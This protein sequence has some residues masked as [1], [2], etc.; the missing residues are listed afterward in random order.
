MNENVAKM[1]LWHYDANGKKISGHEI[2]ALS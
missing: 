2:L 1:Y